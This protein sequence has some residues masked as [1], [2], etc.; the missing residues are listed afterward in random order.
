M[1]PNIAFGL[2]AKSFFRD[3]TFQVKVCVMNEGIHQA[4]WLT[5]DIKLGTILLKIV[6]NT[7]ISDL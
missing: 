1:Y 2:Y 4:Q 5:H 6:I 7:L 3:N